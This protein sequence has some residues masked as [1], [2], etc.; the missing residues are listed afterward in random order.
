MPFNQLTDAQIERLDMLAEEAA[1]VII[2]VQKIKRHGY[3][4]INPLKPELGTNRQQL[5]TEILQMMG[6]YIRMEALEEV[7][8]FSVT[9]AERT[10]PDKLQWTHH[11]ND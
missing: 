2:A 11:Q 6:V 7:L 8:F 5:H 4:S 9:E 1:E 3:D 10:W